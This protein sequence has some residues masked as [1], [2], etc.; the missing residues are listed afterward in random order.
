MDN[1]FHAMT[2][3]TGYVLRYAFK[4][5]SQTYLFNFR[6][7][8]PFMILPLEIQFFT[9]NFLI[10]Q[11]TACRN[12]TRNFTCIINQESQKKSHKLT[13]F[14]S[15]KDSKK[16]KKFGQLIRIINNH[17]D[18]ITCVS[19]L[20]WLMHNTIHTKILDLWDY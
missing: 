15:L 19:K 7:W 12:S 1:F 17:W 8:S 10:F 3:N 2:T 20:V 18:I 11:K 5:F 6:L 14:A 4:Q 13:I 16:Y 9:A